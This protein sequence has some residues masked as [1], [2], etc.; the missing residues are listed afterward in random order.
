MVYEKVFEKCQEQYKRIY[1]FMQ[2]ASVDIKTIKEN[3]STQTANYKMMNK[4]L[5]RIEEDLNKQKHIPTISEEQWITK[6]KVVKDGNT[7]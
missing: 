4:R 2:A 5:L 3:V 7:S 6:E 1:T